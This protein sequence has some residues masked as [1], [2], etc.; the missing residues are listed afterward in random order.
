MKNLQSLAEMVSKITFRFTFYDVPVYLAIYLWGNKRNSHM[1]VPITR[2]HTRMH[3]CS[4][5]LTSKTTLQRLSPGILFSLYLLISWI[6]NYMWCTRG[7]TRS[8][9]GKKIRKI[10]LNIGQWLHLIHT[11]RKQPR[12]LCK[13]S[14]LM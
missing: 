14:P 3:F 12:F 1:W 11:S 8:Y 7:M 6:S 4:S 9:R 2:Q 5:T 13:M 10:F